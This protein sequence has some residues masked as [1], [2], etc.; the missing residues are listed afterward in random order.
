MNVVKARAIV[1][2]APGGHITAREQGLKELV[3]RA[4]VGDARK[5]AVMPAKANTRVEHYGH[6]EV[7]LTLRESHDLDRA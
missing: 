7:G 3:H 4:P 5:G 6:E 1:T 2:A